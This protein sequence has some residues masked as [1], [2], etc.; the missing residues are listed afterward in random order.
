MH[1][2][3]QFNLRWQSY[4]HNFK[5][6]LEAGNRD[7]ALIRIGSGMAMEFAERTGNGDIALFCL[8]LQ[9]LARTSSPKG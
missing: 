1:N 7:S 8:R 9:M 4:F 3:C 5:L 6:A 2:R